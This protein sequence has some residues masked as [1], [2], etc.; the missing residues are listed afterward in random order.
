[1]ISIYAVQ[2]KQVLSFCR[3]VSLLFCPFKFSSPNKP[4]HTFQ[5]LFFVFCCTFFFFFFFVHV[6]ADN[7]TVS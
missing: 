6:S 7:Y 2:F 1:M 4:S 5:D 3:F